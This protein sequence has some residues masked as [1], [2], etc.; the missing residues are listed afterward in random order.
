MEIRHCRSI[1]TI[2]GNQEFSVSEQNVFSVF[3]FGIFQFK[4]Y[5]ANIL[6]IL[7]VFSLFTDHDPKAGFIYTCKDSMRWS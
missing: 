2:T 5:T 4:D 7:G 1:Y 6:N 3:Y